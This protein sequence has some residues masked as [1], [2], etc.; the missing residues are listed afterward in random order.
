MAKL[1]KTLGTLDSPYIISLMR[2]IETQSNN[3]IGKWTVTYALEH[4]TPIYEKFYPTDSRLRDTLN[5]SLDYLDGKIK[6]TVVKKLI[7]DLRS[8]A[9]DVENNPV[10]Q[11]SI[12]AVSQAAASIHNPTNSLGF[13]F[14]GNAAIAY[15]KVG[16]EESA[17][18]YEHLAFE[19]STKM[20]LALKSISVENEPNPA[21]IN[22]YC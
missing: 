2:S 12:R 21:N 6:L 1:R 14:Y 22:W 13:V 19:E 7:S 16:L 4:I 11:A 17:D 3:T 8:A 15:D 5:A 18:F 20:E 9:K 10:A